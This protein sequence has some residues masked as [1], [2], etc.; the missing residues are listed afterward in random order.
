MARVPP[1]SELIATAT[2]SAVHLE[3][4]DVY[5]P[6][7][8]LYRD[9]LAGRPIPEP[10]LPGWRDLVRRH[11]ARGVRFRRARIISEPVS[12]YIRYEHHITGTS[13]IAGGEDIRWLP[14][15]RAG[16]LLVPANDFWVL[17]GE[18]VRFGYFAGNGEFLAHELTDDP[19][20]ASTCARAFEAVWELATPHADYRPA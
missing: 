13:N 1:F 12:D 20:I 16:G 11:T 4:R 18:V 2:T 6:S 19:G 8:P 9:W 15:R 17:D 5:I 10:A 14:R 7:D 3:S